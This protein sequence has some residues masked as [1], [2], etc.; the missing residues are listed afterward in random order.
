MHF[1]KYLFVRI[2]QRYALLTL[3]LFYQIIEL[4]EKLLMKLKID[5]YKGKKNQQF[6]D[7]SQMINDKQICTQKSVLI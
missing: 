7:M 1:V 4:M 3:F 6:M 2:G 5:F